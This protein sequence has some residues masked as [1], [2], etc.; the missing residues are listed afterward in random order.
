MFVNAEGEQCFQL[1]DGQ[2]LK[3]DES[4]GFYAVK[5][6]E[7]VTVIDNIAT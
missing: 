7:T 1:E 5:G 3:A 2:I 6:E 4:G